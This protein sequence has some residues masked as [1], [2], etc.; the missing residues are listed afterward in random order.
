MDEEKGEVMKQLDIL[1]KCI[2][3]AKQKL[4]LAETSECEFLLDSISRCETIFKGYLTTEFTRNEDRVIG[5]ATGEDD[6]D[7]RH[8]EPQSTPTPY[9]RYN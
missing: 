6:Q 8:F 9:L 1:M 3:D 2:D 7:H 5:Q 4:N